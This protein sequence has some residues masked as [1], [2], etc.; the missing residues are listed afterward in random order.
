MLILSTTK[1]G[2]AGD[3]ASKA[4]FP[5]IVGAPK[6]QSVMHGN[7]Q[8]NS[9]VGREAQKKRGILALK[10]PIEHGIVTNW[11]VME[12]NLDHTFYNELSFDLMELPV[13]LTEATLNPKTNRE[14]LI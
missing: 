9:Y 3:F 2:F 11:D 1:V 5:S 7:G 12:E 6:Y 13:L 4:V 8:K 14:K 10:Y